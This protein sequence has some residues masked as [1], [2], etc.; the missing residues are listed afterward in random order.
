MFNQIPLGGVLSVGNVVKVLEKRFPYVEVSS[1]LGADS[2]YDT[3]RKVRRVEAM[4]LCRMCDHHQFILVFFLT[5][6]ILN[7]W[8]QIQKLIFNPLAGGACVLWADGGGPVACCHVQR[9]P[10]STRAVGPGWARDCHHAK[11]SG[12][13]FLLPESRLPGQSKQRSLGIEL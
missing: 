10:V 5:S 2:S 13:H 7:F 11:D 3:N 12:D 4:S 8:H 6:F 1:I 9:H